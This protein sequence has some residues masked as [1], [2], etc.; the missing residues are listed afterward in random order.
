VFGESCHALPSVAR[1]TIGDG[2]QSW[3]GRETQV[4]YA[5]SKDGDPHLCDW[6]FGDVTEFARR[7]P[8]DQDRLEKIV[9]R[10]ERR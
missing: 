4:C 6:T 3:R 10:Q 5:T 9:T 2:P 7:F 8:I 1:I